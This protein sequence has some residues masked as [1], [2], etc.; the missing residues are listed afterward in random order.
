MLGYKRQE[1]ESLMNTITQI[2]SIG[3][4][5]WQAVSEQHFRET[6]M[7][8]TPESLKKKFKAVRDQTGPTGDPN[9]PKYV[10]L[11][12]I[13]Q[14]AILE[15]VQ[16][17][18][19]N[20]AMPSD[21]DE[22]DEADETIKKFPSVTPKSPMPLAVRSN[23]FRRNDALAQIIAYEAEAAKERAAIRAEERKVD[24]QIRREEREEAREFANMQRIEE[25][26]IRAAER[27]ASDQR[28]AAMIAAI[29]Q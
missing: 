11:A 5:D 2:Q 23:R 25:R 21:E 17:D 9:C 28:F 13:A 10:V 3:S 18:N 8:R 27:E 12:K 6:G 7:Q 1:L 14:D 19:E 22:P 16:L 29:F 15:R 26:E 24:A 4:D 20:D